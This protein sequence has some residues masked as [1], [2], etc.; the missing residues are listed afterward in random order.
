MAR[1]LALAAAPAPARAQ[2]PQAGEIIE[3]KYRVEKVLGEGGMG[4]VLAAHHE[5]LDQRV[6]VKVLTSSDPKAMSRFSLE[7]KATAQM[8]SEHVARV[9]DVGALPSGAPFMV[10]EYLEGC[11]LGELLRLNARLPVQPP[12]GYLLAALHGL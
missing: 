4:V 10:M 11:D 7:A 6:A 1:L 8:K 5:L 2:V 3:G 12:A 9:M